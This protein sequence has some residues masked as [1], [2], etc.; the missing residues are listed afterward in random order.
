VSTVHTVKRPRGRPSVLCAC[1]QEFKP[2][3]WKEKGIPRYRDTHKGKRLTAHGYAF[4]ETGPIPKS[5]GDFVRD[6]MH[7]FQAKGKKFNKKQA[8]VIGLSRA[9]KAGVK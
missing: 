5:A 3:G 1:G 8:I 4:C 9:R 6:E 2:R 7:H